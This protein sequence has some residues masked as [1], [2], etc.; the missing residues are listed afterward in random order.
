MK[1]PNG[2]PPQ[3]QMPQLPPGSTIYQ[4]GLRVLI[5]PRPGVEIVDAGKFVP[6]KGDMPPCLRTDDG[7]LVPLDAGKKYLPM[8]CRDAA[9]HPEC[10]NL[11]LVAAIQRV[12]TSVI[13]TSGPQQGV[14][15]GVAVLAVL[16]MDKFD[17][18]CEAILAGKDV[19]DLIDWAAVEGTTDPDAQKGT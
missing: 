7:S 1:K 9:D 18:H 8:P 16:P 17:G 11:I 6:A 3:A 10:F 14:G 13:Q 19:P 5:K 12:K 2:H 15:V 4:T